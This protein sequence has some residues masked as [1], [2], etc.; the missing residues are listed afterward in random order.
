[1]Y[2][3]RIQGFLFEVPGGGYIDSSPKDARHDQQC[4]HVPASFA[5][6]RARDQ[7]GRSASLSLSLSLS[8]VLPS[9]WG[10]VTLFE[11]W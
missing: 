10:G 2:P 5:I 3:R 8:L 9:I 7:L 11:P 6:R 4:P 1:M